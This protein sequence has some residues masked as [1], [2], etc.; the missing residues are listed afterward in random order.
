MIPQAGTELVMTLEQFPIILSCKD[1]VARVAATN[2]VNK[3]PGLAGA[4]MAGTGLVLWQGCTSVNSTQDVEDKEGATIP[5]EGKE[6]AFEGVQN[7]FVHDTILTNDAWVCCDSSGGHT[8]VGGHQTCPW[9]RSHLS[10]AAAL[11]AHLDS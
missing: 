10:A 3:V 1:C 4:S 2:E 7:C 5:T 11:L 8:G 9:P 6:L